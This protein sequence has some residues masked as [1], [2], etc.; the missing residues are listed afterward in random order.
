VPREIALFIANELRVA[1]DRA[2]SGL[3]PGNRVGFFVEPMYDVGFAND[4]PQSLGMSAGLL[5][6]IP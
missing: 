4:H 3:Q 2:T 5:I 1:I 6:G